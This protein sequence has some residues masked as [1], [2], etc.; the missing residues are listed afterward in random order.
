MNSHLGLPRETVSDSPIPERIIGYV[1]VEGTASV[2]SGKTKGLQKSAKAYTPGSWIATRFREICR[3]PLYHPGWKRPWILGGR[4]CRRL[5][6]NHG[7]QGENEGASTGGRRR[8]QH[9]HHP[10][11]YRW[12]QT[13]PGARV[14]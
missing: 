5:R 14:R 6:G 11:G 7:C 1:S 12:R 13:A 4:P 10:F 2:F 3:R 9:V 8:L